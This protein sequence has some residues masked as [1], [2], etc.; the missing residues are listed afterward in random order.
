MLADDDE[1][2][3][4]GDGVFG[5]GHQQ[6]Q[7]VDDETPAVVVAAELPG[8]VQ[9]AELRADD[10]RFGFAI[11]PY[12]TT[13]QIEVV[14]EIPRPGTTTRTTPAWSRRNWLPSS[15]LASEARTTDRCSMA[16][17]EV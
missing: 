12:L 2:G 3:G 5:V 8:A 13:C 1:V 14:L 16:W 15:R 10:S 7:L 4:L 9:G 11:P 6:L 17:I